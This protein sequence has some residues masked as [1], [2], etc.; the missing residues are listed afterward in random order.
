[1]LNQEGR[2]MF[3]RLGIFFRKEMKLYENILRLDIEVLE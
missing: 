2:L 1:M 3:R